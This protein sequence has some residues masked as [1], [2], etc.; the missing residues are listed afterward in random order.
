M[1][2]LPEVETIRRG[3]AGRIIGKTIERVQV[4]CRKIVL[5]PSARDL[6]EWL[7]Q[8]TIQQVSRRGKFL[9]INAG[10]YVLLVHLG[11]TGQLTYWD[12]SQ[13][14]DD[15]FF[16][17]P[18]TGLQKARQHG[19]DKHTHLSLYFTDGNAVHYRD[20]RRFGK[21]RLYRL[22]EFPEAKEY[23]S[24]GLEPFTRDYSW[25]NFQGRLAGRQLRIKSLLLDQSFVAGVG[26]IYADEALFDAGVHP[27]R[28][29][30][31][32]DLDEKR[33]LFR[34]IPKVLKRGLKYGGTSFQDYVNAEGLSG[35]NQERTKVYGRKGERCFRCKTPIMR[36][37]VG[38]RGSHLCPVCQP[39]VRKVVRRNESNTG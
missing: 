17:H 7:S 6:R 16:I 22:E 26:N 33:R 27:E 31:S 14:D 28:R 23:W 9:V 24:L 11:M 35:S 15:R 8:Q 39:L 18:L 21:W 10:E 1:P 34:A 2:E 13:H 12:Q 37:V 32:L 25:K 19:V 36:I 29:A 20:V 5:K 4:R 3:L 30:G 38:Q